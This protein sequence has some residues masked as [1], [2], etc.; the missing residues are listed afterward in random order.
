MT[1]GAAGYGVVFADATGGF[2]P[3]VVHAIAGGAHAVSAADLNGDGHLDLFIIAGG[4]N[5]PTEQTSVVLGDGA[6]GFGPAADVASG[7]FI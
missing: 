4:L 6:G 5:D 2:L 3:P 1:L 7:S